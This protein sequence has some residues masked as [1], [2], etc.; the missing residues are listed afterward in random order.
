MR[1]IVPANQLFVIGN[2]NRN[3]N[4]AAIALVKGNVDALVAYA[5]LVRQSVRRGAVIG[6]FTS[7]VCGLAAL[8]LALAAPLPARAAAGPWSAAKTVEGRLIAAV[9]ATGE[10]AEI[11]LG[12]ELK[13]KPGWKT[14][15]R[16]PGD[17]G[18]PLEADWTGSANLAAA[19][20]SWPAPRRFTLLGLQTFGYE[21]TVVLPLKAQLSRAG[22]ALELKASVNLLVCEALCVPQTVQVA[23]SL[24]AGEAAPGPEAQAVSQ[25]RSAVP[26]DGRAAGLAVEGTRAVTLDG[27]AALEITASAREAFAAPDIIVEADPYLALA[28]PAVTLTGNGRR[29]RLVL[30]LSEALPPGAGLAGRK[31]TLTLLDGARAMETQATIAPGGAADPAPVAPGLTGFLLLALLGGFILNLMPCVLPVLSLKI[32]GVIGQGGA[33]PARV[34][35]GFLASAAGIVVSFLLLAGALAAIKQAGGA[36]GWGIQFQQ[37]AFIAAMAVIVTLFACN[38]W[39]FFEVPLPGFAAA[40]ASRRAGP[41][42]SLT[43][44]FLTGALATLLA[45]P[46]S[47][48]F[49]GT[50]VGFALAGGALD[51][52][53]VF[54]ALGLGL[55]LPYLGIAAWPRLASALPRPGLWMQRLKQ[56][57]GFALAATALWLLSV[58]AALSGLRIT[59]AAG[60]LLL[61]LAAALSA[62][63]WLARVSRRAARIAAAA[64]SLAAVALPAVVSGA[65]DEA[66]QAQSGAISWKSFDREQI[67]G[68]VAQ[69]KTVFVD[70]TA[71]WCIT[72][73]ANKKLVVTQSPVAERLSGDVVA[74][75]ADWTR[76]DPAI[77]AFLS[78][79]GRYGIPFNIVYGPGAPSGIALPELLTSA[80]VLEALERAGKAAGG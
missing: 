45:T 24:P 51:I 46:C 70:V 53:A 3:S 77:L 38:M 49:L 59:L 61:A 43:G 58:L 33:A 60:A 80:A 14:Y 74:M 36:V 76:P 5:D 37:P 55:A 13:L 31:I 57:L 79:H 9:E 40:G 44:H 35:A 28:P 15:W 62:P 32:I 75:R 63:L 42:E 19:K 54:L 69:G 22:R 23:L 72:C 73:Q 7:R 1:V 10:L 11:P 6:I 12:L 29:A 56:A 41:D 8:A 25:A 27:K 78:S 4:A 68:L 65:P 26:G 18:L 17:A 34:R 48:P 64:L 20:L 52:V 67:K 71:Q 47:A 2:S 21:G 50:A 66:A 16:S 30:P 39:G